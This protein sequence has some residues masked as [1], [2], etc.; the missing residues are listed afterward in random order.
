MAAATA[1]NTA[2]PVPAPPYPLEADGKHVIL[3]GAEYDLYSSDSV[4]QQFVVVMAQWELDVYNAWVAAGKPKSGAL[5]SA[6]SN[7]NYPAVITDL[8]NLVS[9]SDRS[10]RVLTNCVSYYYQMISGFST[11][12]A[13]PNLPGITTPITANPLQSGGIVQDAANAVP[14]FLSELSNPALW[15]RIAEGLVGILLVVVGATA[16]ARGTAANEIKRTAGGLLK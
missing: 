8:Q 14:N 15:T 5:A 2:A 9:G 6:A 16:L 13:G 1:A 7:I 11:I 10:D 3:G 4:P 12:G